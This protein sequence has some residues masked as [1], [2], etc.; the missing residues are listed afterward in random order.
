M[1]VIVRGGAI[2]GDYDKVHLV[3][4]GEYLPFD[5][6]LR[7]LGLRNF[8]AIPGGFEFG[9]KRQPLVIP[10]MPSAAP[11]VCYEAIFPGEVRPASGRA[12]SLPPQHHQRRLVW[13]HKRAPPAFR[14]GEAADN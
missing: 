11:L 6:L 5:R 3:P 2:A 13:R 7:A 8:V 9:T 1:L 10:G 12:T 14:A 4:F